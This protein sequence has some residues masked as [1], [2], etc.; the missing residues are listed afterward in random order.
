MGIRATLTLALC[1]VVASCMSAPQPSGARLS[2]PGRYEGYSP[3]RFDG[4]ERTSQY[5]EMRD[6]TRIA[7]DIFRPTSGGRVT[8]EPLPVV[9][10]HTPYNR[11]T[12]SGGPTVERYPGYAI[13]LS[14]YG[15]VVAVADFR[16]VYASFGRNV[17]YNRGEWDETSR[18]DSYDITEWLAAQPWSSGKVGMWGCSAAGGSQMQAMTVRPPSLKAII[19][20]SAEFDAYEAFVLGGVAGPGRVAPPGQSGDNAAIAARDARAV[21]VDGPEGPVQLAQAVAS[22]AGNIESPGSLPLRDSVS[23]ATGDEWWRMTSPATYL[24]AIRAGQMG[25]MAVANWDEAGTRHGAFLTFNNVPRRN[26]K[27]LVGPSDHCGWSE[28]KAETGFD[29]VTEELRFFDYWLK[30]ID[31]GVMREPAVTYYT[32]NAP[33]GRA[34]RVSE[35]WPLAN[36]A[37]TDF[38]LTEGLLGLARPAAPRAL[39]APFGPAAESQSTRIAAAPGGLV[40]QSAPLT[41]AIE[42]TGHPVADLWISTAAGDVDVTARIEDVAPDGTTR[43]HQMLGRLRASHRALS[44]APYDHLGLPWHSYRR[45]DVRGMP[46]GE[47]QHLRFDL[48]PMSYIFQAG[49]RIRLTVTFADPQRRPG[50]SFEATLHSSPERPS[51]ITLPLIPAR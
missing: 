17:G 42:I 33:A 46:A 40:F 9:W 15:Y 50:Q 37:R 1:A 45:E 13:Q 47:P 28:V 19:P 30:G 35:T 39:T 23:S 25:V 49:H 38:Y 44:R 48:L 12:Y 36:E 5:I 18:W 32:Y 10:M 22:H 26:A 14:K 41:E 16:G 2:S 51:F 11:R 21:A 27:L 7:I 31:N 29:L 20:M 43:S 34:W 8:D 24:D 4:Y 6:G 3:A